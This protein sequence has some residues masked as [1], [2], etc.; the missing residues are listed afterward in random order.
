MNFR[1]LSALEKAFPN[2][3][4]L[5]YKQEDLSKVNL[6]EIKS[7]KEYFTQLQQP[8]NFIEAST[9]SFVSVLVFP[10]STS[11]F[12]VISLELHGWK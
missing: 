12:F 7:V 8:F 5:R 10:I 2:H 1:R 3:R 11:I 4:I 6:E 9:P